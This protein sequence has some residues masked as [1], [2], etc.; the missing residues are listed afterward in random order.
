[1]AIRI[2]IM[3]LLDFINVK[4]WTVDELKQFQLEYNL[5]FS[6]HGENTH[7]LDFIRFRDE[8]LGCFIT[9]DDF[10]AKYWQKHDYEVCFNRLK[11]LQKEWHEIMID[12]SKEGPNIDPLNI[13]TE[14][15]KFHF[16][17]TTDPFAPSIG[18]FA[19]SYENFEDVLDYA[20][21][22]IFTSG[23]GKT[24]QRLRVCKYDSCNKLFIYHIRK[25]LFC[26]N[27]CRYDYN[28]RE[29][30]KSGYLARHQAKG[31]EEKPLTYQRK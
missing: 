21:L 7:G 19:F 9:D 13:I 3:L 17:R 31:R 14:R 30:I 2:G 27:K 23:M 1:M 16:V 22:H 8:A 29:H 4:D 10:P 20:F 26:G 25:Q 15:S 6:L 11:A 5:P 18:P 28:N 12:A 24:L